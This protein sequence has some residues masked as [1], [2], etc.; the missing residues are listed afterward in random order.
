MLGD[1][2][3]VQRR[4]LEELIGTRPQA[5]EEAYLM[6]FKV[7]A[8]NVTRIEEEDDKLQQRITGRVKE[9]SFAT[10]YRQ[11]CMELDGLE[12]LME[13]RRSQT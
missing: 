2:D 8:A 6:A 13:R 5:F 7:V 10:L 11:L 9:S 3:R 4:A 12:R 1:L